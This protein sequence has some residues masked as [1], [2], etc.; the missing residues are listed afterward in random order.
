MQ[1]FSKRNANLASLLILTASLAA[2][3]GSDSQ[4][5]ATVADEPV[6]T[7]PE[8]PATADATESST[9]APV[10]SEPMPAEPTA[11]VQPSSPVAGNSAPSIS[12]SAI[13][14]ATVGQAYSFVPTAADRDGDRL[15][16][17]ISSKPSWATF[18]TSTGRLSG[19]PTS[20]HVGSHEQ[21]VISV[22]DGKMTTKLPQFAIT[23]AAAAPTSQNLAMSWDPPTTNSDGSTLTDL[24]GYRILYGVQ[25]GVY[26][27]SIT[28]SAGLSRYTLE[29]LQSGT[30]YYVVMVATNKAGV[31]SQ[32]S[33]E[34]IVDMT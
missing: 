12:G 22:T 18:N 6:S 11:P 10:V 20:A 1:T 23:V 2:C 30:R 15:Q 24:N 32:K 21:I 7:T 25:P 27:K 9:S 14:N 17:A 13:V 5:G 16:F 8:T 31:E 3:G 19:V 33:H 34:L 28:V 4:A 26:N 29:N